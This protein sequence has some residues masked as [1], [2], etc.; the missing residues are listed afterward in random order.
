MA[1]KDFTRSNLIAA[2]GR[3]GTAPAPSLLSQGLREAFYCLVNAEEHPEIL[4]SA[5]I[6]VST[7]L[8]AAETNPPSVPAPHNAD[9]VGAQL[10][11]VL[12][13]LGA[14]RCLYAKPWRSPASAQSRE[15]YRSHLLHHFVQYMPTA[16]VDGCWLQGGLR[17]AT[18]H[19][20]LGASLAGMYQ[21]QVRAFVAD[22]GRHF[23]PDFRAVHSRVSA[24]S[25]DVASHSFAERV[26]LLEAGLELP[27]F[28]LAI[29]QFP[30]TYGLEILGLQLAWQFLD[31]SAF[32]P[33]LIRD[34]CSACDLPPLGCDLADTQY[35]EKGREM[36]R[37]AV[38]GALGPL[39]GPEL[40]EAWKRLLRGVS[41]CSAL[42]ARWLDVVQCAAPARQPDPRQEMIELL[43]RKA[44]HARGF[45]GNRTLGARKIDDFFDPLN[46]DGEAM[47]AALAVS[48]WVKAG[49]ADKSALVNRLIGFGGPMLAVFT[50]EEQDVIR[51]WIDSLP[52]KGTPAVAEAGTAAADEAA[53]DLKAPRRDEQL[54]NEWQARAELR[55]DTRYS[56]ISVRDLYHYLVN[57]E[58]HPGIMP[59]AE[60]F[61][62]ERLERSMAMLWKGDRP[63][64]SDRYN[65]RALE[66]WV[67]EKH[68]QQVDSY[69][70]PGVLPEASKEAFIEGTVQLAHGDVAVSGVGAE[71]G[72]RLPFIA[73]LLV[74]AGRF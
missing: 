71:F 64:P 40:V 56:N 10:E 14:Q 5:N 52:E 27:V 47:L 54:G 26:D 20:E 41:A 49:K 73:K 59:V 72:A 15:M 34:T 43:R 44:P 28:L 29:G 57:V 21:Q 51:R 33:D 69:R 18:A 45:H 19:T 11:Q 3:D 2:P 16:L 6:F 70:P 36:A 48:P 24:H 30:R 39:Q 13:R 60:N 38:L 67:Y 35:L 62:R 37:Q 9:D 25:D 31:L 74:A 63:I 66:A 46:F 23:V 32:G 53:K 61:A 4:P 8:S 12:S 55:A 65:P 42:W 17:V 50:P 68:R 7:R 58:L 22:T 1:E